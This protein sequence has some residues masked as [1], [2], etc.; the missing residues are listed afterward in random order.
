MDR[1]KKTIPKLMEQ[2]EHAAALR[3]LVNGPPTLDQQIADLQKK[4][5][6]AAG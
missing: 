2:P 3:V 4:K 1:A 6:A 5:A